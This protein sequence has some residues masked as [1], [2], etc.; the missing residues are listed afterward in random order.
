VAAPPASRAQ[1]LRSLWPLKLAKI[2]KFLAETNKT[3][4]AED[5]KPTSEGRQQFY[6][7]PIEIHAMKDK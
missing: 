6:D 5:L 4:L 2:I 7:K 1:F 3:N